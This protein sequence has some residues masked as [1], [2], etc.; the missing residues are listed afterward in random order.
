MEHH[1]VGTNPI[2]AAAAD[3][4]DDGDQDLVTSNYG[5]D[6][7]SVMINELDTAVD[8][9]ELIFPAAVVFAAYPNPLNALATI[10]YS[11]MEPSEVRINI[12]DPLG[13]EIETLV[14]DRKSAGNHRIVWNATG[15]STGI[16]FYRIQAGDYSETKKMVLLK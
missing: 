12:Y 15:F 6:N 16:Y 10:K 7:V 3:L 13:R 11:L 14:H 5:S 8:S 9:G 4:D 2:T 1:P